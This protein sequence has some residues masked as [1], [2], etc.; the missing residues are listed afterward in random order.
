MPRE[1]ECKYTGVSFD[2]LRSRLTT[3]AEQDNAVCHGVHLERNTVFD[4]PERT[5]RRRNTLLRLRLQ[6]WADRETC[7]LTLKQPPAGEVPQGFKVWDEHETAVADYAAMDAVLH[8][9]GYVP[10]FRYDKVREEWRVGQ[11][12]VV[13]DTLIF[14]DVVELEG[15]PEAI[16]AVAQQLALPQQQATTAT[17]HDLNRQW[18]AATGQ[19]PQDDFAFD[20]AQAA[21]HLARIRSVAGSHCTGGPI[22]P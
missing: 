1:V 11:V 2:A 16:H 15:E 8:G 14:G 20:N 17:Y 9:L 4:T 18:R 21:Q 10:V 6:A 5:L 19:P 12:H 3:L 7:I 13:L 22:T